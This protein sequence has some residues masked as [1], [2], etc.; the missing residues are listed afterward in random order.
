MAICNNCSTSIQ[1]GFLFCPTCGQSVSPF[2]DAVIC[3]NCNTVNS[4]STRF[5][6]GCGYVLIKRKKSVQCVVCGSDNAK[7]A[8]FCTVCGSGIPGEKKTELESESVEKLKKIVPEIKAYVEANTPFAGASE[9]EIAKMT[10]ICPVCGKVNSLDAENCKRCGRNKKRTAVLIAKNRIVS[11]EDANAI[12]DRLY[13]PQK[14]TTNAEDNQKNTAKTEGFYGRKSANA[15]QGYN[16]NGLNTGGFGQMTP[17]VQPLAIVP[18]VSQE[19]PLWQTDS[20][21][22]IEIEKSG[23]QS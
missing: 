12:P 21:D 22:E 9:A 3:L 18:Y 23:N 14:S 10:Y 7:D 8:S 20:L 11:F 4:A 19:Q 13:K 15:A 6:K 2:E 1:A 17:I 5:C 16:S